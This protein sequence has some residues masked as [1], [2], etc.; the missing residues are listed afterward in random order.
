M[1][2]VIGSWDWK[3]SYNFQMFTVHDTLWIFHS[4]WYSVDGK[5]WT[6]IKIDQFHFQSCFFWIIYILMDRCM[7]WE[8]LKKYSTV[9]FKPGNIQNY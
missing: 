9:Y 5:N 3:K 8:I 6:K 1:D 2:Q 4:G 7:D